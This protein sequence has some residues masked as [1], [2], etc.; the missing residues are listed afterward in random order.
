MTVNKQTAFE[1]G[2]K[3]YAS[4]SSY[5]EADWRFEDFIQPYIDN[6]SMEQLRYIVEAVNTNN[7]LFGRMKAARSNSIIRKRILL[8]EN[9]FDFSLYPNF[10]Y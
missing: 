4:S 7:Q 10:R 8:L 6:F 9:K 3:L 2:I 1:Y 5:D